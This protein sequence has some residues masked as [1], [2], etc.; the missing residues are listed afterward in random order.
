MNPSIVAVVILQ[1]ILILACILH[2]SAIYCSAKV[3]PKLKRQKIIL[4]NLSAA[5][6]AIIIYCTFCHILDCYSVR[7]VNSNGSLM[8]FQDSLI[9]VLNTSFAL[10]PADRL[11]CV[12]AP[13]VY[14]AYV[15]PST[16]KKAVFAI[17]TFSISWPLPLSIL[18]RSSHDRVVEYY[19][20]VAQG[21]ILV[22]S[23]VAYALIWRAQTEKEGLRRHGVDSKSVQK[24]VQRRSSLLVLTFIVFHILPRSL[25]N[26][27]DIV[28][29]LCTGLSHI[30]LVVDPLMY[31]LSHPAVRP[32]VRRLCR[33]LRRQK[34]SDVVSMQVG[35]HKHMN[36]DTL[37]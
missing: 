10:I 29:T 11:F 35:Y 34:G 12:F 15:Q 5:E 25:S 26:N 17:W 36:R 32:V 6:I 2:V 33:R 20:Y 31:A 8:V 30:G 14:Q 18:P 9:S 4:L 21:F 1:S 3:G 7:A 23:I 37:V 22:V 19:A 24:K 16:L 28:E 13:H 27:N